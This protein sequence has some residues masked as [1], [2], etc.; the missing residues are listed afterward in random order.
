MNEWKKMKPLKLTIETILYILIFTLA[1]LLRFYNLGATPL[2]E[3]EAKWAFQAYQIANSSPEIH[4]TGIGPQ[5]AYLFLTN[6]LFD[7]FGSTNFLARFWPALAGVLLILLPLFFRH[8]FGSV[9]SLIATAGLALDPGLVTVSR[10]AGGPMMALAFGTMGLALWHV[11]KQDSRIQVLA[12]ISSGLALLS[13]QALLIG[14]SGLFL[15]W[16]I[17]RYIKRT[18]SA[19]QEP[20]QPAST[21]SIPDRKVIPPWIADART[22]ILSSGLTI[23][24]VGTY[25]F[26]HPQGLAAWFQMLPSYLTGWISS[27]EVSTGQLMVAS[28]VY[29]PLA[30]LLALIGI[31]RWLVRQSLGEEPEPFSLFFLLLWVIISLLLSFL[32]PGRQV[33]DLVWTLVPLWILAADALKVYIPQGKPNL[34]SLLQAGLILVLT[35]LFWNTLIATGHVVTSTTWE[36]IGLRFGILIGIISLGGLTTVLVSLGWSW[37]TSRNGLMWGIVIAFSIYLFSVMWGASQLRANQPQEL[38]SQPPATGQ[39]DLLNDTMQDLSRWKTGLSQQID[40]VSIVD[41]PSLRWVLRDYPNIRFETGLPTGALPSII[42]TRQEQ[43]APTLT[44]AYRGQDFAWWV[45]P[46]WASALPPNPI[47]WLTFRKAPLFNEKLI[48]WARSDLFPGGAME[49]N[50]NSDETP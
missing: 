11:R 35:A 40:A 15:A 8:E 12:G 27:P 25:F 44:A 47:E 30:L 7:L 6:F 17:H 37:E 36:T 34:I 22:V 48:L 42:I 14:A 33:S 38:W 41:V 13:G 45:N 28:L 32:Y 19:K 26:Q 16:F 10:Q 3:G 2:S 31:I 1:L 5:P 29:Q 23:I 39:A 50:T 43:E 4:D 24:L 18:R 21:E 9:A 46:G 49:S 20:N